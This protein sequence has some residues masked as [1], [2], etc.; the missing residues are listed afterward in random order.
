[1]KKEPL[2][3]AAAAGLLL[4]A[5]SK[6]SSAAAA[7]FGGDHPIDDGVLDLGP[8][9]SIPFNIIKLAQAIA[10]AE[11]FYQGGTSVQSATT[12]PGRAN[13][14][15]DLKAGDVGYGDINGITIFG[16]ATDG[17]TALYNQLIRIANRGSR[18]Y[19]PDESFASFGNTWS[20]GDPNWA[21]NVSAALGAS[22]D[23]SILGWMS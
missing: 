11:G 17:W 6:T 23:T 18:Y 10:R 2:Y 3:L 4:I 14:P 8:Q 7:G 22:P 21:M 20:G 19:T 12:I 16:N 9:S 1:M 15:G 13:N 5:W